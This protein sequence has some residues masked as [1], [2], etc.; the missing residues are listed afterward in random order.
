MKHQQSEEIFTDN[1]SGLILSGIGVSIPEC[2]QEVLW[3]KT[4]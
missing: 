1:S 4:Y 2:G 3:M